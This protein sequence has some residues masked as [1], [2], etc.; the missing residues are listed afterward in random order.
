MR[1]SRKSRRRRGRLAISLAARYVASAT[2]CEVGDS[3][4]G[5]LV[6]WRVMVSVAIARSI[7]HMPP[8]RLLRDLRPLLEARTEGP[9]LGRPWSVVRYQVTR[10]TTLLLVLL[11]GVGCDHVTLRVATNCL[12]ASLQ[13]YVVA[14]DPSSWS[15]YTHLHAFLAL[16]SIQSRS[17]S[18]TSENAAS[19]YSMLQCLHAIQGS[20]YLQSGIAKLR[21]SGIG[22][23]RGDTLRASWAEL[24]TPIGKHLAL[25]DSRI[26]AAAS[27]GAVLL[28]VAHLPL[29]LSPRTRPLAGVLSMLFH[30]TTK[31]TMGISFW[32]LAW[33]SVPL[34]MPD[35]AAALL[36]RARKQRGAS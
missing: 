36:G 25:R 10:A 28:E 23:L 12:F 3:A 26:A 2:P 6:V 33:F 15:Y 32:H 8:G 30:A 35:A 27:V 13:R 19:S 17:V 21:T 14:L 31:A 16:M 24:G 29:A 5:R 18:A 20:V 1:F 22:W 9:P 34:V 4:R 11:W 7:I